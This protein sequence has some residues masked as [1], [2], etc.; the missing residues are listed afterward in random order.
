MKN[1]GTI[2]L[3]SCAFTIG[4]GRPTPDPASG[5]GAP[6]AVKEAPCDPATGTGACTAQEPA[7]A[8]VAKIVFVGK[9]DACACTRK[10]VDAGWAVLEEALGKTAKVEVE[11]IQIDVDQVAVEAL[12]KKEPFMVLPVF[13]FLDGGGNVVGMLQGGDVT[14]E[15]IL[16]VLDEGGTGK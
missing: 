16:G 5:P 6:A 13:Y 1:I 8:G 4:C 15:Q 10:A 9:A 11:T 7:A 2:G 12:K 14:K 3:V